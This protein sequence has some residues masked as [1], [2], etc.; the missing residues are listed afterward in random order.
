MVN[1]KLP[2]SAIHLSE[3]NKLICA[4]LEARPL[5]G[6]KKRPV[7][8]RY[9]PI[10]KFP[11]VSILSYIDQLY[12]RPGF[13]ASV[14]AWK[15]ERR[16]PSVLKDMADGRIWKKFEYDSDGK[17]LIR[18]PGALALMLNFDTFNPFERSPTKSVGA[19]YVAIANLPVTER[20][21]DPLYR[22]ICT[23]LLTGL[24]SVRAPG[25]S[26]RTCAY[27]G[28]CLS[29]PNVRMDI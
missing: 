13:Q 28:S 7:Y 15:G 14:D 8:L 3:E 29:N 20:S 11:F 27:L 25:T 4:A 6:Q 24:P 16:H 17:A 9:E 23:V 22:S 26:V 19:L 21:V 5:K 12:R 2:A 1:F 10:M 18:A